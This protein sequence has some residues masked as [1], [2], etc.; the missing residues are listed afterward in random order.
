MADFA[1]SL[2]GTE[3][4]PR[5]AFA[6][7]RRLVDIHRFDDGNGR[8][9]RLL[10]NLILI[11]AGYPPVAIRPVDRVA[12]LEALTDEAAPGALDSFLLEPLDLTMDGYLTAFR[13]ALPG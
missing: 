2:A 8:T 12:Y 6:A 4:G 11:Q 7:H 3:A 13:A 10:M 9:A 5:E 1:A